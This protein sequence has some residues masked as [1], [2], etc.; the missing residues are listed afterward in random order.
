MYLVYKAH[1]ILKSSFTYWADGA[2]KLN[3]TFLVALRYFFQ[4]GYFANCDWY[5]DLITE[6]P[7]K[8]SE[9][10]VTLQYRVPVRNEIKEAWSEEELNRRQ[11]ET[12][13]RIYQEERRRKYLQELQD[14]SN[15]R[16]T[17]NFT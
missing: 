15:R 12:M 1:L 11:A 17:D 4:W 13:R 14:M 5:F 10:E 2:H 8:Y 9:S 16:H 6:S 3:E 7:H